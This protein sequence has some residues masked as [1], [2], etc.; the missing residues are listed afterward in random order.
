MAKKKAAEKLTAHVT[1]LEMRERYTRSHPIPSRPRLALMRAER[2]PVAFYR[3]LYDQV[4]RQYH[5]YLRR[6]MDDEAVDAVINA[7]T[8]QI[9]VLYADGCPAGFF[10]LDLTGMPEQV[11]LAYFG[12]C[13]DYIGAG[14]G[15][16]FLSS[17]VEAAWQHGPNKVTVHTNSLDHP[18]ALGLYQRIGFEPVGTGEETIEP[19]D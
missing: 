8:T 6:V 1:F 9:D 3:Y 14:L 4:G 19:W 5:W 7:D 15:K 13:R 16:W 2:M 10:E 18:R 12:L 17:A 11:E